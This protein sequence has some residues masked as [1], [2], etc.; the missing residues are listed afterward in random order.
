MTILK[1]ILCLVKGFFPMLLPSGGSEFEKF[2]SFVINTYNLP[3]L[4]S[5]KQAIATMI[6]HMPADQHKAAPRIFAKSV[7]KAMAN[8][9]AYDKI[10]EIREKEAKDE[11]EQME[12]DKAKVNE[13]LPK[14]EV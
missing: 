14:Q 7:M 11:Q 9:V 5:Y 3:D 1:K 8:Q 13:P 10:Q 4:P 2:Y 12:K 6:M